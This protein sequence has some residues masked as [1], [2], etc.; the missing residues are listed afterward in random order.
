MPTTTTYASDTYDLLYTDD[1]GKSWRQFAILGADNAQTTVERA[2]PGKV[3][4]VGS[5]GDKHYS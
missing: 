2:Y 5:G 3:M 1:N 4:A